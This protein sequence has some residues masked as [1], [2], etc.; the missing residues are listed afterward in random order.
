V[1]HILPALPAA[2]QVD[3]SGKIRCVKVDPK[4]SLA[5]TLQPEEIQSLLETQAKVVTRVAAG[6]CGTQRATGQVLRWVLQRALE[7]METWVDEDQAAGWCWHHAV[8][9]SRRHASAGLRADQDL[10]IP[11]DFRLDPNYV[12]FVRAIRS[13][14]RQQMEAFLLHAGESFNPRNLGIAMDCSI[15]AAQTHLS[16]AQQSLKAT[17][18]PSLESMTD[19]LRKIYRSLAPNDRLVAQVRTYRARH[20]TKRT[21]RRAVSGLIVLAVLAGTA[22]AAWW[23]WNNVEV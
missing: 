20:Q 15:A 7:H 23:I 17:I 2:H 18:G 11:P 10:L 8:L 9:A 12:A 14:S 19:T 22:L 21:L 6:L 5:R 16:A 3:R 4:N 1:E 13:L